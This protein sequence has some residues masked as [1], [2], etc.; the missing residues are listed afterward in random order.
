[1]KYY[2]L[3]IMI[4]LSIS[5]AS[6]E[7]KEGEESGDGLFGKVIDFAESEQGQKAIQTAKEKMQ[8]KETQDK[9]KGIIN[10]DK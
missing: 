1:M 5:C 6:A 3:T 9:V 4:V 7:P 8:D 2:L 10:K